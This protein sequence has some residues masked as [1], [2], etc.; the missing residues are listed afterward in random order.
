MDNKTDICYIVSHGFAARMVLQTGLLERLVLRGKRVALI[1]PDKSDKN[2]VSYCEQQGFQLYEFQAPK[3]LFSI[4]YMNMRKYFLEDVRNNPG[5][6]AKHLQAV[7]NKKIKYLIF[8]ISAWVYYAIY[9]LIKIAPFIRT[10][11]LRYEDRLLRSDT[12]DALIKE[13]EAG[14][15]V[16]TYPV[17]ISE[18]ILLR[19]AKKQQVKTAI[20]LLSWDNISCKGHFPALADRYIAWGHVMKEEFKDYYNIQDDH[21][22][23][24]GVPHFDEHIKVRNQ[25]NYK[26]FIK[27]L[28]LNPEAPYLFVAMSSPIFAPRGIDIVE[29]LSREVTADRFG[30]DMQ[31]IVRPHPQNV[32]KKMGDRTWLPR[33]EAIRNQRVS[34][35]YPSVVES[36]LP[37]SMQHSDMLRLSNLLVGCAVCLNFGSTVSIDALMIG[38]PVVVIAF[39]GEDKLPWYI[40]GSRQMD[41]VHYNKLIQLGGIRVAWSY[42]GLCKELSRYLQHP[43]SDA[44]LRQFTLSTECG[45]DDGKAT[46][47]VVEALLHISQSV[48]EKAAI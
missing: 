19:A 5:L 27:E 12:A 38:R 15:V 11:F 2:L 18:A 44:E 6:W 17:N 28:G 34:V 33:L 4:N 43:D 39:D 47:R 35:D 14:L 22:Y 13:I 24:C 9:Q 41:Y 36:N 40:S 45:E 32:D 1:T 25:P 23:S 8:N 31:L 29:W 3:G 16:A 42:D 30:A 46:E 48:I 7:N 26:P 20:H 21:I 10:W 37:W